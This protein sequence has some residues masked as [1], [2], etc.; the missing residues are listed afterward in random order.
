M[1]L[2]ECLG[3][4]WQDVDLEGCELQ[5][6]RQLTRQ[7]EVGPPK[8]AKAAR[9]VPLPDSVVKFLAAHKLRSAHSAAEDFVFANRSGKGSAIATSSNAG[10]TGPQTWRGIEGV[11]FHDLR[12]AFA[13][14]MI[15]NGINST[16]LAAV[17][18]HES[19]TI[20][21]RVYIHQFNRLKR[22]DKLRAA[23]GS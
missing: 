10:S 2:G 1:R 19:S 8:T 7:G 5:V 11:T 17:M 3:L 15:Y 18:G 12:H 13:S 22:D 16:D 14:R 23:M 20:T 6:R 9:Q 4:Q 21:E